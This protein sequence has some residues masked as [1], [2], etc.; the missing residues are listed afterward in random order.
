MQNLSHDDRLISER[1]ASVVAENTAPDSA[2]LAPLLREVQA[3]WCANGRHDFESTTDPVSVAARLYLGA[4]ERYF[5]QD[6]QSNV[7]IH[8]NFPSR[9]ET[10]AAHSVV[11]RTKRMTHDAPARR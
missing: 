11:G 5:P 8:V 9:E 7:S 2:N 10:L 3:D 6:P 4:A 1:L